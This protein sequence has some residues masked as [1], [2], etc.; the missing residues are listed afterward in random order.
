[1][2]ASA[3]HGS[4][5]SRWT[6]ACAPRSWPPTTITPAAR[7]ACWRWPSASCLRVAGFTQEGV[8]QDLTFLGLMAMMDPPRPEVAGAIQTCREAGIRMVMITGDYG[9]TAES[10]ARRIGMLSAGQPRILT[11]ADLD[12]MSDLDL[13]RQ[14]GEGDHL[15]PHG[16]RAQAAPGLRFPGARRGGGRHRRWRERRARAAQ[17]GYRD[18][19]GHHRHGCGQGGGRRHPDRRQLRLHRHGH[20]RGARRLTT[21]CASSS[22][23]SSPATSRRSCRS[24]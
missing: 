10:L 2:H 5:L 20:R 24:C 21:T 18:R 15:C 7:C 6:R 4:A 1:M 16:A 17:G 13:Q 14:I 8:E 3:A 19:D 23:T 9:L 12:G 22:P 11:G